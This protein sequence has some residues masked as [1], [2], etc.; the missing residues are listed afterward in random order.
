[1]DIVS[2]AQIIDIMFSYPMFVWDIVFSYP[3]FVLVFTLGF[4]AFEWSSKISRYIGSTEY[5]ESSL[6]RPSVI[7]RLPSGPEDRY[8]RKCRN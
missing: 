8:V 6:L 7:S 1:M 3:M 4:L 5:D 2:K